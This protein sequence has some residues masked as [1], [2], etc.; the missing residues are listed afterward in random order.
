MHSSLDKRLS[1]LE[2]T[3]RPP[4]NVE[5]GPVLV[6]MLS[7]SMM[8]IAVALLVQGRRSEVCE[9]VE[10]AS[11][12]NGLGLTTVQIDAAVRH[13]EKNLASHR[14]KCAESVRYPYWVKEYDAHDAQLRRD[15]AHIARNWPETDEETEYAESVEFWNQRRGETAEA[16]RDRFEAKHQKAL[17]AIAE[18]IVLLRRWYGHPEGPQTDEEAVYAE[19]VALEKSL[20]EQ[21]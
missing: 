11:L 14:V 2:Q 7:M 4:V 10:I 1:Q 21:A 5:F 19:L 13:I 9:L 8:P 3:A 12:E 18:R 17:Q 15:A 20:V 16:R 6:D